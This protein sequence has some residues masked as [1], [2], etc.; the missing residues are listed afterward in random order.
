MRHRRALMGFEF[1][2][3]WIIKRFY[4][5]VEQSPL[6][7]DLFLM[8]LSNVFWLGEQEI[9]LLRRVNLL[10][11]CLC[12]EPSCYEKY[13]SSR[14]AA[15][16]IFLLLK[17]RVMSL[18]VFSGF[19]DIDCTW[20][21]RFSSSSGLYG[22][23]L[24]LVIAWDVRVL[25]CG[26]RPRYWLLDGMNRTEIVK[27]FL[28][29]LRPMMRW[30]L[31]L[32]T[33]ILAGWWWAGNQRCRWSLGFASFY[34]VIYTMWLETQW[35]LR[36]LWLWC[37]CVFRR[38]SVGDGDGSRLYR[39]YFVV[40]H[41]LFLDAAPFWALC[42]LLHSDYTRAKIPCCWLWVGRVTKWQCWFIPWFCCLW[43]LFR[44]IWGWLLDL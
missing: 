5:I 27:L 39:E 20:S 4:E 35:R 32:L 40:F 9:G 14:I 25:I 12:Y 37:W 24:A 19:A 11:I 30:G 3:D 10:E 36:I 13:T 17:P 2:Q 21:C 1:V 15:S 26:R 33:F 8:L 42:C 6:N 34:A 7:V 31:L 23:H 18:V 43:P 44:C 41:Y 28:S 16:R 22:G 38:W 29:G